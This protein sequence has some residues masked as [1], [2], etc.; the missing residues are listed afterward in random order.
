MSE[1]QQPISIYIR[2]VKKKTTEHKTKQEEE[3][4]KLG[5]KEW[6]DVPQSR[7]QISRRSTEWLF[8]HTID[9]TL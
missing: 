7:P 1:Q 9:I 4:R 5:D 6:D 8:S 2:R 3:E